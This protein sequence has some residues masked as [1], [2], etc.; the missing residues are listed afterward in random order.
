MSVDTKRDRAH[1]Q[2]AMGGVLNHCS[3]SK[4]ANASASRPSRDFTYI[5]D[6]ARDYREISFELEERCKTLMKENAALSAENRE[7]HKDVAA[8]KRTIARM[9]TASGMNCRVD[10]SRVG[11]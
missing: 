11:A 5:Q 8:L 3:I 10:I 6:A 1:T 9:S 7:L 2:A 4:G